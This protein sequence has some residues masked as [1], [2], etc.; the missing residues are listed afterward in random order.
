MT[1]KTREILR[2]YRD[3]VNG[4]MEF[5][6]KKFYDL[7]ANATPEERHDACE[8]S[9]RYREIARVVNALIGELLIAEL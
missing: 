6:D 8:T 4:D 7:S 2:K 5:F 9:F 3:N 1:E